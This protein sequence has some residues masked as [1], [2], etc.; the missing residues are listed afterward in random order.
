MGRLLGLALA[1]TLCLLGLECLVVKRA[2][3]SVPEPAKAATTDYGFLDPSLASTGST[4][5]S[6]NRVIEPPEWAPF[7]LLSS[8]VVLLI[9][10]R[11]LS[12]GG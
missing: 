1:V 10:A 2:T 4:A 12:S 11:T 7:L 8:G 9:Y 6:A 3:L 5:T